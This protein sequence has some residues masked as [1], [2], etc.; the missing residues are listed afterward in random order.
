MSHHTD[1]I[2]D[3]VYIDRNVG[4]LIVT[5]SRDKTIKIWKWNV[6]I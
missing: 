2:N 3:M 1:S 4:G 6:K 5:A